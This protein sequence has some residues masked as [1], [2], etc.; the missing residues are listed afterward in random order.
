[1]SVP[2]SSSVIVPETS[3]MRLMQTR[4]SIAYLLMLSLLG[5][6]SGVESIEATVTG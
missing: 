6:N 2:V 5:S 3:G 4:M 1:M